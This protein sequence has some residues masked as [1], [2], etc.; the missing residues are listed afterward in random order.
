MSSEFRLVS[1]VILTL[2]LL[3]SVASVV[4]VADQTTDSKAA[5]DPTERGSE[6][7][8]TPKEPLPSSGAD[9]ESADISTEGTSGDISSTDAADAKA[10]RTS[11]NLLGEE[12]ASSGE[13]RRNENVNLTLIDNNVLKEINKRMGTTATIV[14]SFD[15]ENRWSLGLVFIA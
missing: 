3:V 4:G 8:E 2:I 5:S 7:S 6:A 12:D 9:L 15:V 13:S 10:E 14:R 1:P 11:L